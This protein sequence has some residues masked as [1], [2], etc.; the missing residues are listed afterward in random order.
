MSRIAK[1][2]FY[3]LRKLRDLEESIIR[4]ERDDKVDISI[5][6]NAYEERFNLF[7][8]YRALEDNYP[9]KSVEWDIIRQV[10]KDLQI[11]IRHR[12]YLNNDSKAYYSNNEAGIFELVIKDSNFPIIPESI[13]RL[14]LL[15]RLILINNNISSFP[16]SFIDLKSLKELNLN[17]NF[18]KDLPN[19]ISCNLSLQ[20]IVLSNNKLNY[21]PESFFNL[22]S[23]S[24]LY[25][26]NNEFQ[27]ISNSISRLK[28]LEVLALNN[29][30]LMQLPKTILELK[31]LWFLDLR[32]NFF[33]IVPNF[34][35]ESRSLSY[36][37]LEGNPLIN[38]KDINTFAAKLKRQMTNI[39][40]EI[41]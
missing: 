33:T 40:R 21:L 7:R 5:L 1:Q 11:K 36:I 31:N 17:N 20:K 30:K 23:V 38:K 10:E 13:C 8:A 26:D 39:D 18:I 16:Q 29:N 24:Q 15:K 27:Q 22:K 19:S 3:I 9:I 4:M 32:N 12:K 6:M 41:F 35:H 28:H 14:K 2:R 37:G 34:L 25:L